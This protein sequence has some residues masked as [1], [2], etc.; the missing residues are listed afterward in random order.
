MAIKLTCG[1][2]AENMT[3]DEKLTIDKIINE[4]NDKITRH[5]GKEPDFLEVHVKCHLK[6][7]I[8]KRYAIEARLMSD[9]FRFEAGAE[10]W[11]LSNAVREA[12]KKLMS[13][14]E[15]KITREKND[16]SWKK[17]ARFGRVF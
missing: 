12:M 4:Y 3:S 2:G 1:K 16:K 6:E 5:I 15:H 13:E 17:K 14:I 9:K 7:G 10:E 11:N 8:S